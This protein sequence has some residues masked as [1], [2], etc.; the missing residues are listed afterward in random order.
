MKSYTLLLKISFLFILFTSTAQQKPRGSGSDFSTQYFISEPAFNLKQGEIQYSN[1][2]LFYNDIKV[3]VTNHLSVG[4]SGILFGF[5]RETDVP[6]SLRMKLSQRLANTNFHIGGGLK[7]NTELDYKSLKP[8]PYIYEP[9]AMLTFG[10][11]Q[12]NI[13]VEIDFPFSDSNWM[14]PNYKVDGKVKLTSRTALMGEF[15]YTKYNNYKETLSFLG[16]RSYFKK[17]A[18]EYGILMPSSNYENHFSS[19]FPFVGAKFRIN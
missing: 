16:A 17:W 7:I 18:L 3:G 1:L 11:T 13:N 14:V 6:M 15:Y 10:N 2:L 9:F 8:E 12:F 19:I 5:I 4:L